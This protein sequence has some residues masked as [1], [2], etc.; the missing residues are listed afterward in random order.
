MINSELIL[1]KNLDPATE[2]KSKRSFNFLAEVPKLGGVG[3]QVEGIM[4]GIID[5]NKGQ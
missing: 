2:R 4:K 3:G 1:L 5:L